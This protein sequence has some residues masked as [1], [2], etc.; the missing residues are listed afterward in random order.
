LQLSCSG[1]RPKFPLQLRN[2]CQAEEMNMRL[3]EST[4]AGLVAVA[5][6]ILFVA[7]VLL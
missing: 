1:A 5:S 7:T 3:F 2:G 6:Q 4:A